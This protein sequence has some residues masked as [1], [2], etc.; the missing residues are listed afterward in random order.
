MNYYLGLILYI[1]LHS[2][3][4]HF[5]HYH[6]TSAAFIE[7]PAQKIARSTVQ[8]LNISGLGSIFYIQM[9]SLL[10][11]H[12]Y[13]WNRDTTIINPLHKAKCKSVNRFNQ[14]L[15]LY[16]WHFLPSYKTNRNFVIDSSNCLVLAFQYSPMPWFFEVEKFKMLQE[17][18]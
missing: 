8:S 15:V 6:W 2:N 9:L 16:S 5:L 18:V 11:V 10:K 3:Y 14:L 12:A 13:K 4:C 7:R 1:P 17:L